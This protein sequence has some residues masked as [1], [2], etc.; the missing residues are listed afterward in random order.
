MC[1]QARRK[2]AADGARACKML[3][4]TVAERDRTIVTLQS[5]ARM[6]A[7]TQAH[8]RTHACKHAHARTLVQIPACAQRT[9][10]ACAAARVCTRIG[11][12]AGG[13]VVCRGNSGRPNHALA[14]SAPGLTRHICVGTDSPTSTYYAHTHTRARTHTRTQHS[15]SAP[16]RRHPRTMRSRRRLSSSQP[17]TLELPPPPPPSRRRQS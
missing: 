15:R 10:V 2:A 7:C 6:H 3:E 11:R 14:T 9:A 1:R 17:P 13:E 4:D 5:K 16:C 12:A 8:S